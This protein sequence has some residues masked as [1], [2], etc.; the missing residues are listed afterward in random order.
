MAQ[1]TTAIAS[2]NPAGVLVWVA[3]ACV[4]YFFA[5]WAVLKGLIPVPEQ[6]A[7]F[8]ALIGVVVGLG[9]ML[10]VLFLILAARSRSSL[11]NGI[12][13]L[14]ANFGLFAFFWLSLPG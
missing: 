12:G 2:R 3:W 10:A 14:V 8:S 13:A 6:L 11:A 7:F 5:G 4:A 1:A 9:G